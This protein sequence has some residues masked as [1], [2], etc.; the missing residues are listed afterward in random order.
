MTGTSRLSSTPTWDNHRHRSPRPRGTTG[1]QER[2]GQYRPRAANSGLSRR[3][4]QRHLRHGHNPR[5]A[6]DREKAAPPEMA[7][8]A[9][10]NATPAMNRRRRARRRTA[11]DVGRGAADLLNQHRKRQLLVREPAARYQDKTA[12]S[13]S[14]KSPRPASG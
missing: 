14:V 13:I 8:A 7:S 4:A 12:A 1:G 6:S 10:Q 11:R 3:A 5:D 2:P 9:Q